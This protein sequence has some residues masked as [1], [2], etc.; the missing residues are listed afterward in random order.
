MDCTAA[1]VRWWAA[2]TSSMSKKKETLPAISPLQ[3]RL[4]T[5]TV[6]PY[7][8]EGHPYQERVHARAFGTDGLPPQLRIIQVWSRRLG[9]DR[10]DMEL[11]AVASQRRVM[12]IWHLFPL[13]KQARV[14]IWNGVDP[15]SGLRFIDQSFPPDMIARRSDAQMML[16]FCN[17]STYQLLGSDAYNSV[18]GS[19]PGLVLFSEFALSDPLAWTYI[20]PILRANGGIGVFNSTYR[21]RNHFYKLVQAAKADPEWFVS[22]ENVETAKKRDGSFMFPRSE[23]EKELLHMNVLRWREEYLNEPRLGLEGAYLAFPL[24]VAEV[25]E[26]VCLAPMFEADA[27]V[28]CAWGWA[29]SHHVWCILFQRSDDWVY[30]IGARHWESV[31]PA[32]A[33]IELEGVLPYTI[34]CHVLPS[35]STNGV[36]GETLEERFELSRSRNVHTCED[37]ELH[38]GIGMVRRLMPGLLF[39]NEPGVKEFND[40]LAEFRPTSV[41]AE[42]GSNPIAPRPVNDGGAVAAHALMTLAEFR[43]AGEP[44]RREAGALDW[45]RRNMRRKLA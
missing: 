45:S 28:G 33:M 34:D 13:H 38:A 26:R 11:A 1:C 12:N 27:P 16:E 30:I 17:G 37:G 36:P 43:A 19:N 25:Q 20:S 18:I 5:G 4:A 15:A 41:P 24:S 21:G 8:W 31:D 35:T 10:T 7:R 40:T 6:L 3:H 44:L 9:K 22:E 42:E 32:E 29:H 23:A 39:G 14:A 2:S